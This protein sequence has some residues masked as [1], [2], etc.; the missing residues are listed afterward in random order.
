MQKIELGVLC[1]WNKHSTT[2]LYLQIQTLGLWE[3]H[4]HCLSLSLFN[5]Y[6]HLN[7]KVSLTLNSH[8]DSITKLLL[9]EDD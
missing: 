9:C 8:C 3:C 5:Y 6:S 1:I 7:S 2:Q 4:P